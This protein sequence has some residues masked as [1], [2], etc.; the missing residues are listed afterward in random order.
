MSARIALRDL[1]EVESADVEQALAA[2]AREDAALALVQRQ[3]GGLTSRA[4]A[5]RL[6]DALAIDVFYLLLQGWS[7]V[8][9]VIDA[10][11]RSARTAS[12]TTVLTLGAHE[13]AATLH[14]VLS[15]SMA[16]APLPDLRLT[17]RLLARFGSAALAL[18][19]GRID[20]VSPRDAAL[21]LRLA[22]GDTVLKHRTHAVWSLPAELVPQA[23]PG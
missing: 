3:L 9:A 1:L 8:P 11:G 17:V 7:K 22:Y 16:H 4:A 13:I 15:L 23:A 18:V 12:E 10:L 6:N 14:P 19:A 5:E 21:D 2:A 20:A